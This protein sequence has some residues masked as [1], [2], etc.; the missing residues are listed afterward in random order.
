[1]F[2]NEDRIN[3]VKR[4]LGLTT[5]ED[6]ALDDENSSTYALALKQTSGT[7]DEEKQIAAVARYI[8]GKVILRSTDGL[9]SPKVK[10]IQFRALARPELVVV[11]IPVNLSDRVERPGRKPFK[12]KGLGDALYQELRQLEG[13]AVTLEIF[14]PQEIIRGV[15]EQISYPIQSNDVVGSDTHYA[16]ITVRGT[17]QPIVEAVSSTDV[18]GVGTLGQL[19]FGG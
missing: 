7:G 11:Q 4:L 10:S 15:V 17:R 13:D 1:M 2:T 14:E 12:V 6:E 8:I 3:K 9:K 5:N 19:R 16:V 18:L